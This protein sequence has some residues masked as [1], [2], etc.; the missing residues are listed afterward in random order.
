MNPYIRR[1]NESDCSL[2]Q[3]MAAQVWAPTYKNI[4]SEEQLEYMFEQMYSLPSLNAQIEEGHIYYILYN[5]EEVPSGYLSI[6]K[7]N[8]T[9]FHL[10]KIYILPTQ[11]GKGFGSLLINKAELHVIEYATVNPSFLELNVN[12]MN[13]AVDFYKKSDFNID[14]EGDFDIGNG[15]FMNDYIM[16]KTISIIR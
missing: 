4:L 12:R 16:K 1:A 5:E 15:F 7:E 14:R 9:T 8:E 13:D 6:E 2:I 3:N 11:Q 10:Q